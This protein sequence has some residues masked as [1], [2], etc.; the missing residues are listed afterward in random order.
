MTHGMRHDGITFVPLK[1]KIMAKSNLIANM[2]IAAS[3][4]KGGK[5]RNLKSLEKVLNEIKKET[6]LT[7]NEEA[8][9]LIAIMDR[10]CSDESTDM[11]N[12]TTYFNCTSLDVM[13]FVPSI[14]SLQAKGFIKAENNNEFNVTKMKFK[15]STGLYTSIIEGNEIKPEA[16]KEETTFDQFDFCTV[17]DKFKDKRIDG[18]IDTPT[19]FNQTLALEKKYNDLKFVIETQSLLADI[20]S[21]L[22]FY[23]VC[24]DFQKECRGGSS[25][26]NETL[27]DIYERKAD[28]IRVK[29]Q[30]QDNKHELQKADLIALR[31]NDMVL[32][33]KGIEML[34]GEYASIYKKEKTGLDRFSFIEVVD[35][36]VNDIS[37]EP[38]P[39]EIRYALR[40][41]RELEELNANLDFIGSLRSIIRNIED[42]AIFYLICYELINS[43]CFTLSQLNCMATK[44]EEIRLR[45]QFKSKTHPLQKTGLVE[46]STE[47][48]LERV[49][50]N[51]TEKGKT[52]YLADDY[53]LFDSDMT[54]KELIA[55]DKIVEKELFFPNE[56]ER[57]LK[58]LKCSLEQGNYEALCER[59]IKNRL[60]KGIAV[61]LYGYPG[62]GK[63]ES[64]MQIARTTG[65]TIMHVDISQTK[66]CW[67]GESEKLIKGVFDN[68]RKLC[69]KSKIKP[70]LLFNEADAIFAKRKDSTCS[71]VAQTENA[72]QN[73]I[74]EELERLDGILIATTN[75]AD[76]LDKAFERRFLF[77]IRYEKPDV[78]SKKKIWMSKLPSLNMETALHL[79]QTFDF[80]GGEID[81]IS[82]KVIVEELI[83]GIKIS[84]ET[85][86]TLCK[87]EKLGGNKQKI[88]F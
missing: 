73:I 7:T 44:S 32:T 4:L 52:L 42:R 22:L 79:A 64:V 85:L 8:L 84:D 88:G 43:D 70:I 60:P 11:S 39:F 30:L 50:L 83:K 65:R 56:T 23:E 25:N 49:M 3:K 38:S 72:M 81:N 67:F 48:F 66:T 35:S 47:E 18:E 21:R 57:Q 17:A 69:K 20:Q 34:F 14:N 45:R 24:Y 58:S 86:F 13:G 77:K 37:D 62:T 12:L 80:S 19:L 61:L 41:I 10:Q 74:L 51:L 76:N 46:L 63:T 26:I 28:F 16:Y 40:R 87:E 53:D 2:R 1:F 15:L 55:Y 54:D 68:Y 59:L 27:T 82:R 36:L 78:E 9:V 29:Q 33:N 6:L 5:L 75:L 71:S 31:T